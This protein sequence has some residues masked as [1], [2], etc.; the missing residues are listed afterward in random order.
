[1]VEER[2]RERGVRILGVAKRG[3]VGLIFGAEERVGCGE[4]HN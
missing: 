1:M 2:E 3:N 4:R